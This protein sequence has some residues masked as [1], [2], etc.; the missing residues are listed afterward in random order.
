MK[1]CILLSTYNGEKYLEEQLESLIKQENVEIDILVR[2]DGSSDN[3]HNILNKWQE[4]GLLKWYTG[5]NK[6]Y[7][8]SFMDLVQ[9]S[10]D[11]DYYPLLWASLEREGLVCPVSRAVL[12]WR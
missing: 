6:G 7:A 5:N 9:N 1:V 12:S 11:Y 8:K 10:G 2:D 4:R 3:T